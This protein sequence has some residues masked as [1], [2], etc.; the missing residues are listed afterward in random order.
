MDITI[1]ETP[2]VSQGDLVFVDDMIRG[3][4]F[5]VVSFSNRLVVNGR[6]EYYPY[7]LLEIEKGN[8]YNVYPNL[9]ALQQFL[10]TVSHSVKKQSDYVISLQRRK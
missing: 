7:A 8:I 4:K 5:Q 3:R 9:A 2:P 10:N 6:E 1:Q